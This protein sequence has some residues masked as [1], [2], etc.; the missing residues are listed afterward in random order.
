MTQLMHSF[1]GFTPPPAVLD[2]VRRGEIAAFC[3]F[4]YNFESLEQFR[5]LTVQLHQ[6]AREGACPPPLIGTDQEGGQ[7]MALT[8]GAT[9]LPGNMAL[10]ATRSPELAR[11]A[12]RVLARELLAVGCNLNFAPVLDLN[13]NPD[14]IATGIRSFGADPALAAELGN[15]LIAGMQA[16]GVLATAKHF[17][18]HGDTSTDSH[19][20]VPVIDKS[21]AEMEALELQPFAAAISGGVAAIM[22]AHIRFPALDAEAVA[23]VSRPILTGLLR[24]KLGFNG[25]ILT[26]AMDM[27][28]VN[29]LGTRES[30][31]AALLAGADLA[32]LGH[33]PEQI[34]L[35]AEMR[36]LFN[37]AS[38]E[39]IARARAA[40]PQTYPA[41]DV[42]GCAEHQQIA[43]AIADTSI[44]LVRDDGRLPLRPGADTTIAVITVRPVNLTPADTSSSVQIGLVTDVQARHARV[45]ALELPYGASD[46]TVASIVNAA[47]S[48]DVVIVGTLAA[49]RDPAQAALVN[50]LHAR[51]AAP[52]VVALRTPYDLRAFPQI[53]TYLCAYGIRPVTTEAVARVLFGEIPARGVLPCPIPGLEQVR[54]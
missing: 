36:P 51:G 52:I 40:L 50:E 20:D 21:L 3:L 44:T 25:L 14:N 18:G 48:A 7:L 33:L 42:I 11:Q 17:P 16:E 46:E 24:E 13:N 41:L 15:A 53:E 29:R 47:L 23:T 12:G 43:Q 10:G 37:A 27:Q 8:G 1:R 30:I 19:F 34:E 54:S 38:L 28:A 26:D 4:A 22:S 32:L 31:R 35:T 2:G 39:R 45:T 6:A 5:D 9:E 49:D